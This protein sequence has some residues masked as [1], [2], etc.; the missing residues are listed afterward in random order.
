MNKSGYILLPI[1]VHHEIHGGGGLAKQEVFGHHFLRMEEKL[2]NVE[3]KL[4]EEK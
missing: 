4:E 1:I 3:E 2:Q